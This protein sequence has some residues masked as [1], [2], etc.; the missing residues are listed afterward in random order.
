M[1]NYEVKD[2]DFYPITLVRFPLLQLT[3]SYPWSFNRLDY[4][5]TSSPGTSASSPNSVNSLGGYAA[6][7]EDNHMDSLL[8]TLLQICSNNFSVATSRNVRS[9]R[10][11]RRCRECTDIPCDKCYMRLV[12]MFRSISLP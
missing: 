5:N 7:P 8:N 11:N 10:A 12:N 9:R 1:F 4:S 2:F 3:S 6:S